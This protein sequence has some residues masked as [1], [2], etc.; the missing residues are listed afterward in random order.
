MRRVVVTG[1]AGVTALGNDW[2][3]IRAAFEAGRT[4]VRFMPEWE[5]YSDINTRIAAPVDGFTVSD[6]YPRKKTRTMGRVAALA[7]TASEQALISA[8]LLDDPPPAIS[9]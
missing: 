4:G 9:R 6:R 5:R 7:V 3:T 1:M 2:A 8:G